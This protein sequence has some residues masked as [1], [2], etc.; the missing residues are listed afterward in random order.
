MPLAFNYLFVSFISHCVPYFTFFG[1]SP[2][3]GYYTVW[4]QLLTLLSLA[5]LQWM[6]LYITV[7]YFTFF[8]RSPMNGYC[9]VWSQLLTLLSLAGLQWMVT[10]SLVTVAYFTFFGRSPMNG[11]YTV[12]SQLLTLLSLAGLQWMV[13]IQF[14][15]SCLLY[16]LWQVSNEWLLYSFHSCLLYFLWHV[17][18]EWLLY[19]LVTVAYFTFFGRS[20]MNGSPQLQ[21]DAGNHNFTK[22]IT[23]S[24]Y[25][26][27]P[28]V[29]HWLF[30]AVPMFSKHLW[31]KSRYCHMWWNSCHPKE[32]PFW[33]G[34][35]T[36]RNLLNHL[37]CHQKDMV[38]LFCL[39]P[40]FIRGGTC[41]I[42]HT[43]G[44]M[45]GIIKLCMYM[46]TSVG[47]YVSWTICN[48]LVGLLLCLS[49]WYGI[50]D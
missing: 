43:I 46:S 42:V 50:I 39:F 21:V 14:G 22:L 44:T 19:S 32:R 7:A 2:M 31:H 41:T 26:F 28:L 15:H 30:R 45:F 4:S 16:F 1:R 27:S 47:L 33:F 23:T 24:L 37:C 48:I 25:W 36:L 34:R 10:I 40:F 17:S 38:Y 18:N 35:R 20:P 8:G 29:G 3:N 9:T 6:L 5:G 11:Y 12:W 49:L 13:T